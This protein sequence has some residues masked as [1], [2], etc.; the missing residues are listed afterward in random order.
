MR[1]AILRLCL[2]SL[3]VVASAEPAAAQEWAWRIP[4]YFGSEKAIVAALGQPVTLSTEKTPLDDVIRHLEE[5]RNVPIRYDVTA[6]E[7]SGVTPDTK[8]TIDVE[9]VSLR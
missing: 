9:N 4:E 1:L 8:V 3:A 2:T 7:E 5:S 6:M